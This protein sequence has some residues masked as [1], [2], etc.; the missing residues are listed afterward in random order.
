LR[1]NRSPEAVLEYASLFKGL[2]ELFAVGRLG[3]RLALLLALA[4]S[5]SK[6]SE[7]GK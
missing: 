4:Y 6:R 3:K 7:G 2:S 5:L 1:R